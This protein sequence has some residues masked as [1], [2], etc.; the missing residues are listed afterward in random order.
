MSVKLLMSE[1]IVKLLKT[2]PSEWPSL[3]SSTDK[4]Y[5]VQYDF[6]RWKEPGKAFCDG[7]GVCAYSSMGKWCGHIAQ[8][9]F[10]SIVK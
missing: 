9:C 7:E 8:L 3:T 10:S 1:V 5:F 4:L 6:S 2:E